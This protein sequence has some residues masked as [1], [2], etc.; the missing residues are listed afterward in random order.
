MFEKDEADRIYPDALEIFDNMS[1][2][3]DT[4]FARSQ[5]IVI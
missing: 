1:R 3:V 2:V 4:L 5:K